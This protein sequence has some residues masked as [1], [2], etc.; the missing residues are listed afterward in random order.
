MASATKRLLATLAL[1]LAFACAGATLP[2][3][4]AE[5]AEIAL[6]ES[7]RDSGSA[8][9]LRLFLQTYP[10]SRFAPLAKLRLRRLPAAAEP[11]AETSPITP[12]PEHRRIGYAG[13]QIGIAPADLQAMA[14]PSFRPKIRVLKVFP[15]GAAV[16]AGFMVG[17]IIVAIDGQ[18]PASIADAVAKI[19]TGEP[20]TTIAFRVER[21]GVGRDIVLVPGDRFA[22]LWEA[23]HRGDGLAMS[24]L[25]DEYLRGE[26]VGTDRNAAA[27]LMTE[28][29]ES[30]EPY[31]LFAHGYFTENNRIE[32]R[33]RAERESRALA[34][35]LQAAELGEVDAAIAA[36][37]LLAD[38]DPARALSLAWQAYRMDRGTAARTLHDRMQEQNVAF[39]Q[40][41]SLNDLLVEAAR[42]GDTEALRRIGD[43]AAAAGLSQAQAFGLVRRAAV[44]GNAHAQLDLGRRYEHGE[45]TRID[46]DAALTW[47]RKA[48]ITGSGTVRGRARAEVGLA[49]YFGFGT[50]RDAGEAYQWFEAASNDNNVLGHFYVAYLSGRGEGTDENQQRAVEYFLKAAEL[51]DTDAMTNLGHRYLNGSGTKKNARTAERWFKRAIEAGDPDGHCG[52]GDLH[53]YGEGGYRQSYKKAAA[54]YTRGADKGRAGCQFNLG[55]MHEHGLGMRK[56]RSEAIRLYRL[57]AGGDDRAVDQLKALGVDIFDPEAIQRLLTD[58]GYD[59][60]PIDGKPGRRTRAAI[61]AFQQAENIDADGKP[62]AKLLDRLRAAVRRAQSAGAPDPAPYSLDARDKKALA[63]L[64]DAGDL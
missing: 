7:V 20:D 51:G 63:G 46:A 33:S 44:W 52:L 35:Y 3:Q 27:R 13:F 16:T 50:A 26:S 21:D 56:S 18:R 6:W 31:A 24:F 15:F 30:G 49:H 59:P 41:L 62:S 17:D 19:R 58:L 54:I 42:F 14:H 4:A 29:R 55:F 36:S 9:E 22:V 48:A 34:A 61:R 47:Y 64:E 39:Y 10:N 60:G 45:G 40:G 57:A 11:A 2:A 5:P 37:R 23:A 28:A 32:E 43:D 53:Y 25:A 12:A 1:L 38:G 8:A